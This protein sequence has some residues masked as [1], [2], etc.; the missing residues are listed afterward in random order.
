V[1]VSCFHAL[2]VVR[3]DCFDDDWF[4]SLH[5]VLRQAPTYRKQIFVGPDSHAYEKKFWWAVLDDPVVPES[6][7]R[8]P[9]GL[10]GGVFAPRLGGIW[11]RVLGLI[12]GFCCSDSCM[13]C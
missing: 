7:G 1:L 8:P 10:L 12:P 3:F 13:S 9:A 6:I 11:L 5:C 4:Y 2:W